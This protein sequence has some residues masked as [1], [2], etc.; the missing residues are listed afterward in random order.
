MALQPFS[1]LEPQ[2][3][4]AAGFLE[5]AQLDFMLLGETLVLAFGIFS[6]PGKASSIHYSIS[7]CMKS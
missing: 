6:I 7:C 4:L 1:E 2:H 5:L 3:G